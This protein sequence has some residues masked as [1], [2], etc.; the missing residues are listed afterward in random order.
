MTASTRTVNDWALHPA[1][2]VTR[3]A[4]AVLGTTFAVLVLMT[5]SIV[6]SG[7]WA[8]VVLGVSMAATSVRAALRLTIPRILAF[9]ATIVAIPIAIQVF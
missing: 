8:L 6:E 5:A 2:K 3:G 7:S 1:G 9:G 4:V